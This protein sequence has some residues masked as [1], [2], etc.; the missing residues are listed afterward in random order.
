MNLVENYFQFSRLVSMKP[1][2]DLRRKWL[3]IFMIFSLPWKDLIKGSWK[4][5][6]LRGPY[7]TDL[8]NVLGRSIMRRRDISA[9]DF[10]LLHFDDINKVQRIGWYTLGK[11]NVFHS[12]HAPFLE[13]DHECMDSGNL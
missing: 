1:N 11:N 5:E 7:I 4:E 9:G 13:R 8:G 3:S 12:S 6:H 2:F 10:S